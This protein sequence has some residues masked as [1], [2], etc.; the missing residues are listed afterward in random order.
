MNIYSYV[1]GVVMSK[2]LKLEDVSVEELYN[3]ADLFKNFSDSTR[4]RILYTMYYGEMC[5]CSISKIL[6]I[7]QSAISHQLRILKQ[8]KLVSA[9][10]EGK[11]IFY[12]LNDSHIK[13]IISQGL[14]H[15]RE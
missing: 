6:N 1:R 5:V 2:K 9:R 15:I 13:T 3:L 14:D 7:S 11:H 8:S 12:R 10:R 4:I